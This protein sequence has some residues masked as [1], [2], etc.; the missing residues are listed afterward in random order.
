MDWTEPSYGIEDNYAV[1]ITRIQEHAQNQAW[2]PQGILRPTFVLE[3]FNFVNAK[4][5]SWSPCWLI[6]WFGQVPELG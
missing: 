3:E 4:V 6:A 2:N 5:G 1:D